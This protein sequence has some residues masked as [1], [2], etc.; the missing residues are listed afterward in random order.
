MVATTRTRTIRIDAESLCEYSISVEVSNGG[1]ICPWHKGQSGHPN[2]EPVTLTMPPRV[3]WIKAEANAAI[4]EIL[5]NRFSAILLY[6]PL[7]HVKDIV[8]KGP[9]KCNFSLSQVSIRVCDRQ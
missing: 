2:P 6:A 8:L 4:D 3:T 1:I 7:R 5:K 9:N